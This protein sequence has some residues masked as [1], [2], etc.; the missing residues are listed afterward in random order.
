MNCHEFDIVFHSDVG[1]SVVVCSHHLLVTS[2]HTDSVCT[3][4]G[5][6]GHIKGSELC[7]VGICVSLEVRFTI[8]ESGGQTVHDHRHLCL[9][10]QWA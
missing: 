8:R 7:R 9:E 10:R 5:I 3:E 1:V 4:G 6:E 2:S